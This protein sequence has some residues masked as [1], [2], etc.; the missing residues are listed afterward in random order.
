MMK[1]IDETLINF[2]EC[3]NACSFVI[4]EKSD[5]LINEQKKNLNSKKLSWLRDIEKINSKDFYRLRVGI[6]HPGK[7]EDVTN[8]VLNK[9]TPDEKKSISSAFKEFS[10]I[11]ELICL[12]KISEVQKILH[13]K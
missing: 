2:P 7:K 12:N 3:Y 9:F 5:F 13:T 6:D 11:F 8:W 10:N 1:V 4:H